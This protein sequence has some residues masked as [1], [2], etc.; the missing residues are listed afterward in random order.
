MALNQVRKAGI[1]VTALFTAANLKAVIA[2]S[3][4]AAGNFLLA[5]AA[6]VAAAAMLALGAVMS[7][8]AAHPVAVALIALGAVLAGVCIYLSRAGSYTER[9]TSSAKRMKSAWNGSSSW[10]QSRN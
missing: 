6:K 2:V 9:E 8:I 10:R 3:A 4:V 7:F 5:G 1:A